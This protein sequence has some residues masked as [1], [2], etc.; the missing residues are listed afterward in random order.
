MTLRPNA[1]GQLWLLW[2]A[3]VLFG[4]CRTH[5]LS[6]GRYAFTA[7]Q[8]VVDDCGILPDAASL[9]DGVLIQDGNFVRIQYD[10]YDSELTGRYREVDESFYV[11]GSA[12]KVS[13]TPRGVA[14][15]FDLVNIHID[16]A[17]GPD[18]DVFTGVVRVHTRTLGDD[19]CECDLQTTFTANFVPGSAP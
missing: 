7:D 16:G 10:L 11:D 15:T 3:L 6:D 5:P 8:I 18:D 4:G 14:C 17:L 1:R 2:A 19:R 13:G 9:W 12:S